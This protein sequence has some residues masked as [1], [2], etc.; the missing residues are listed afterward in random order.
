MGMFDDR[1]RLEAELHWDSKNEF[2]DS[3][4]RV[5]KWWRAPS[6]SHA[7]L[8]ATLLFALPLWLVTFATVSIP[9]GWPGLGFC[10]G[11]GLLELVVTNQLARFLWR[12]IGPI[13]RTLIRPFMILGPIP[14][15]LAGGFGLLLLG[16]ALQ[17]DPSFERRGDNWGIPLGGASTRFSEARTLCAKLGPKWRLP[18]EDEKAK[19]TPAPLVKKSDRAGAYWLQ[20][21][22]STAPA[23]S[24]MMQVSCLGAHCTTEVQRPPPA[25]G[26]WQHAATA[27]CVND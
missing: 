19:L 24:V 14:P 9:Q 11:V 13:G 3:R 16:T 4:R 22:S 8:V 21:A 15:L 10:L 27:V 1:E 20:P 17:G 6:G 25:Q 2:D 5:W 26:G 12:A 23:P 7:I 18:R